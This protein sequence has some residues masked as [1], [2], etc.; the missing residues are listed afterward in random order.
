[1]KNRYESSLPTFTKKL[2]Y[3]LW[4]S[5]LAIFLI[6]K[7]YLLFFLIRLFLPTIVFVIATIVEEMKE[8]I[9]IYRDY[10][11]YKCYYYLINLLSPTIVKKVSV[12]IINAKKLIKNLTLVLLLYPKLDHM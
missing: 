2:V 9:I 4:V 1:M 3:F 12:N 5:V 8:S 11:L 10:V 7:P 6:K